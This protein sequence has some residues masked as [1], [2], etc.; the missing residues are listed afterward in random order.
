MMRTVE[1]LM[2]I[3]MNHRFAKHSDYAEVVKGDIRGGGE[4][5]QARNHHKT[6]VEKA[7][8]GEWFPLP[9]WFDLSRNSC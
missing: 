6:T 1:I 7:L 5:S 8:H 2:N 3:L 9:H 4:I